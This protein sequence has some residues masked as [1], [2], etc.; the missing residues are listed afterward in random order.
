MRCPKCGSSQ[1]KVIDSREAREGHSIRRRRE[2]MKCNFRFTTYEIVER[3]ELRVVKRNG[4]RQSFDREKLMSGLRKACEKRP[5]KMEQLEQLVDDI[6]SELE[7]EGYREIPSTVIG[8]K[9]MRRLEGIDHV[10]YVRY[11][12]VYRQFE[13][14]GEFIDEIKS[15]GTRRGRDTSQEELF[16]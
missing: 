7:E 4:A 10:A 13:D 2:C 16:H 5:V 15:L 1:D 8:A 6:A 11:A 9:M 3:E 12:S 14:V